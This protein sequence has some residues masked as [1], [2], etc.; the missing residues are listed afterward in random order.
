MKNKKA[1]VFTLIAIALL[2]LFLVSYGFYT[3]AEDRKTTNKRVG[4]LN[5]FV[6]SLEQDLP[7]QLYI[8]GFRTIFLFEKRISE[9]G[10]YITDFNSTFEECFFNGTIYDEYQE[11]MD[12]VT[13]PGIINSINEKAANIN[14]DVNILNPKVSITQDNPWDIKINLQA[15]LLVRDK[16]NLVSWNRSF[17]VDSY[18]SIENFEDPL[19]I[20][21]TNGLISNN[22]NKTPY[23]FFVQ[24]SDISNLEEHV[25]NSYYIASSTA[26]NFIDRLQGK[27]S[28]SPNGI[29]SLV[30][31][32]DLSKQGITIKQKS[33][34]DYIYFS[35]D[36]PV[37]YQILGMPAWFRLDN[38]H[39]DDYEVES[40]T[41]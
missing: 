39:L 16:S 18:V 40:L 15:D 14:A 5:N 27:N 26:P 13:F 1:M 36:N 3:I 24:G 34:V 30:Y 4:T 8:S 25:E 28:L 11:L 21:N 22:I 35:E 23:E 20:V 2:S 41:V 33:V 19:Y 10:E 9:S 31:L 6:F 7:R 32:P 38:E 12:G 37:S 17:S 29:E